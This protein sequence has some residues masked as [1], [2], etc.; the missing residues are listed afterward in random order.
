MSEEENKQKFNT[1]TSVWSTSIENV[2]KDIGEQSKG[3]KWMNLEAAKVA[4]FRHAILSYTII[5]IGPIAGV[6]SAIATPNSEEEGCEDVGIAFHILITIF[7]FLNGILGLAIKFARYDTKAESYKAIATKYA[8]LEGNIRRQLSLC[9]D[10]RV[11][12]G[13]YLEWV[14]TSFDDLFSSA[15]LIPDDIYEKCVKYAQKNNIAIPQRYGEMVSVSAVDSG[16]VDN[17]EKIHINQEHSRPGS[18]QVEKDILEKKA[19]DQV[20]INMES[21]KQKIERKRSQ[22]YSPDLDLQQFSDPAMKYQLSRLRGEK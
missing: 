19:D 12:A 4:T 3:F 10:D 18:K 14:S 17:L 9:R 20:K 5:I 21:P 15:P 7:S 8:S 13:Q 22:Y 16:S 1:I 11:N 6:L 2:I